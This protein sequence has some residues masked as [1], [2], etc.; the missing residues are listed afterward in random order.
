V[1]AISRTTCLQLTLVVAEGMDVGTKVDVWLR[2][3]NC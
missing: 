2:R 1:C 3:R